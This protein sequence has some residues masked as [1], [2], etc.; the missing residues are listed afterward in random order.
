[1]DHGRQ[2]YNEVKISGK[3]RRRREAGSSIRDR[4]GLIRS[5]DLSRLRASLSS[6]PYLPLHA[7]VF[8]LPLRGE[9]LAHVLL[10]LP[11]IPRAKIHRP[12]ETVDLQIPARD[13]VVPDSALLAIV[14]VLHARPEVNRA[15]LKRGVGGRVLGVLA[16]HR[17][18]P[19]RV[20]PRRRLVAPRP[21]PARILLVPIV[22]LN[23][24]I[25][26]VRSAPYRLVL[27][28]VVPPSRLLQRGFRAAA[29]APNLP[30]L[31]DPCLIGPLQPLLR[32][33]ERESVPLGLQHVLLRVVERIVEPG[34]LRQQR[35]EYRSENRPR[36]PEKMKTC[37]ME[38]RLQRV[39][40]I[41]ASWKE[42]ILFF[43]FSRS[44]EDRYLESG[45][46]GPTKG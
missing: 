21:I 20:L 40:S 14:R 39:D 25:R 6:P 8:L 33:P 41:R 44:M 2:F 16:P 43:F 23:A 11:F 27:I 38:E 5:P 32:H 45:N 9:I 42:E 29:T 28:L 18:D 12:L 22:H 1:M 34:G 3:F 7:R 17:R 10:I 13:L 26:A 19:R 15:V 46:G 30:H 35:G 37:R 31:L 4:P 36:R 24:P